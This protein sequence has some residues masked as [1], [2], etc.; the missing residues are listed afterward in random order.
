[1]AEKKNRGGA[2]IGNKNAVGNNGGAPSLFKTPE[3]L[4][5]KIDEYFN[6]GANKKLYPTALGGIVEIPCY[7]LCGLAYFLGFEDRQS[8]YDYK[9]RVEFSCVIKKARLR[10]EMMYEEN[11]NEKSPAGSIFALKNMGW[12][13]KQELTGA[14]GNDL[15]PP[16][17][18][19]SKEEAKEYLQSLDKN[20]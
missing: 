11:L 10:I 3:E 20:V 18:I 12:H 5:A 2:P 14:D 7:T 4:Q 8:L 16:A 15:F 19:L 9:E 1:M 13:D 17:R 6:G